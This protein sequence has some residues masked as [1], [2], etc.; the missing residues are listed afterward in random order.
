MQDSVQP[1]PHRTVVAAEL[2][3]T[4]AVQTAVGQENLTA[5]GGLDLAHAGAPRQH[6]FSGE[7]IG[8]DDRQPVILPE[9]GGDRRFSR[10][11]ASG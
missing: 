4:A 11:D 8:V 3:H 6:S 9:N 10:S 7:Q 2:P 5:K 1:V